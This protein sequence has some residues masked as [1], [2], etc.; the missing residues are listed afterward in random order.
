MTGGGE[1]LS[2]AAIAAGVL[3]VTLLTFHFPGHTYLQSDTQIYVPMLEH[4]EDPSALARDLS[5]TKPHLNF[6]LYDEAALALRWLTRASWENILTAEQFVFRAAGVVGLYLLA[7]ALGVRGYRA[8]LVAAWASLGAVIVGPAVLPIEDEPVPRGDAGGLLLLALG[9]RAS[10]RSLAA[11]AAAGLAFL[12][13]PPTALPLLAVMAVWALMRRDWRLVAPLIAAAAVLAVAARLQPGP[14][15]PQGFWGTLDPQL[16]ALQRMRASYDWVS[17]WSAKTVWQYVLLWA[18][19]AAALLRAGVRRPASWFVGALATIGLLSVPA[20]YLLLDVMKWRLMPQL[21]PARAL[22]FTALA[23]VV[24]SAVAA[25]RAGERRR[26]AEAAAGMWRGFLVPPPG[27]LRAWWGT[28]GADAAMMAR[29][30]VVA[31]ALAAAAGW[32]L[33]R[34]EKRWAAPAL[35]GLAASC[36]LVIPLWGRVENYP[37]LW[38]PELASLSAFSRHQ[39]PLDAVFAFPE[40]GHGLQPGIFRAEADRC[41][42]VDWKSGGQVNYYRDLALEWW[43]RWQAVMTRDFSPGDAARF[44]A[45]GIDY[46]VLQGRRMPA[47]WE[48]VFSNSA[49]TVYRLSASAPAP[50]GPAPSG[51]RSE[52]LIHLR[53]RG[54]RGLRA[55][56]GH[57]N[58]GRGGGKTQGIRHWAGLG[59]GNRQGSVEGVAGGRG[60][61]G[62]DAVAGLEKFGGGIAEEGALVAEF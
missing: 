4:I 23:A 36:F 6:T 2:R 49:Y 61:H 17:L 9:W 1:R 21:Q 62:I 8:M 25:V 28:A 24:E 3:I 60:V 40:A 35:A 59:Q 41:V 46:V 52:K 42:Y 39:S 53:A 20:S 44:R 34:W 14:S 47:G 10:G 12:Y 55:G 27:P 15:A 43:Q 56:F 5:A 7:L 57:R 29:R 18:V 58:S 30:S 45:M 13:H 31:L 19:A 11:G 50:T 48:P 37:R 38:T 26:Y 16:E 51:T 33:S 32:L 22:L 54:H